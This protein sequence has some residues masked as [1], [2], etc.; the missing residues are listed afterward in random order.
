M[1]RILVTG[2][3]SL[4]GQGILKSI[5]E[6]RQKRYVVGTD[7]FPSA[8]GLYWVDKGY[9]LPDIL[10]QDIKEE[11][12][13]DC[14]VEI[15][16][17]EKIDLLLPGLD[18]EIP[19]LA[20][21]R[22]YIENKTGAKI[23]V[24]SEKVVTIG[25]DKWETV[26]FLK[27][28]GFNYPASTL[29]ECLDDFTKDNLFPYIVKP[30]FGHTSEN[31][32]LVKN[33]LELRKAIKCCDKPIIQEYISNDD[34]EYTCGATYL[35]SEVLTLVCLRRTLKNGNTQQAFSEKTDQIDEYINTITRAIKP[36]GPINFQLRLSE[37]GPVIFEINPRF[38]GTTPIRALFGV[39]EVLAVIDAA[40]ETGLK[41][42]Y[43]KK[44][45]VVIRY[46]ESQFIPWEE[47]KVY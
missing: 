16:I 47:Y 42:N 6:S 17:Q 26:K 22:K 33:D 27:N 40:M 30:R 37:R 8:V 39:N 45:G 34:Q 7:Y 19:I 29:P 24:S 25:D 13:L 35:H 15:I 2:A 12:W 20:K 14:L 46:F 5:Q 41:G 32:F 43:R 10:K 21:N 31:V 4:L 44:E 11:E 9:L 28:N 23:L 3:G 38:S 36:Y 1:I 18:F